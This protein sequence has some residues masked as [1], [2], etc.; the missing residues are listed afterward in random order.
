MAK[1][2]KVVDR[3]NE[4]LPQPKPL[5][6]S[7]PEGSKNKRGMAR[8][9]VQREEALLTVANLSRRGYSQSEIA[10]K[11]GVTQQQVSYDLQIIKKRYAA[12]QEEDFLAYRYEKILQLKDI[13]REAWEAW[14]K[15]KED[16][17]KL[18]QE[19]YTD[20]KGGTSTKITDITE[21]RIPANEF[22]KTILETLK[23]ENELMGAYPTKKLDIKAEVINWDQIMGLAL[24]GVPNVVED[25]L[26][27]QLLESVEAAAF[28]DEDREKLKAMIDRGEIPSSDIIMVEPENKE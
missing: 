5:P 18:V 20:S 12:M 8:T 22:L 11:M 21:G 14:E 27:K 4:V 25:A 15:S 1:K 6:G 2:K 9:P 16:Y 24:N 13:R 23:E 3:S 28:I 7:L 19:D 26:K 10:S 17:R